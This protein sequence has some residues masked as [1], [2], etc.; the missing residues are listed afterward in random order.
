MTAGRNSRIVIF[1]LDNA[2]FP[3]V[4]IAIS[5]LVWLIPW[6]RPCRDPRAWVRWPHVN[7][8]GRLAL[9][10]G[11]VDLCFVLQRWYR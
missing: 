11:L 1:M 9:L 4:W 8:F 2:A 5:I 6:G 3:I 7:E 10:A